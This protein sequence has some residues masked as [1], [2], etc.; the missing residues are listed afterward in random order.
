MNLSKYIY[1][2]FIN[3][4]LCIL[5]FFILLSYH[6]LIYIVRYLVLYFTNCFYFSLL[7]QCQ[8]KFLAVLGNGF[9]RRIRF[10]C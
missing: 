1:I 7:S 4:Y 6:C 2:F 9:G 5:S 3:F 10:S 8:Y